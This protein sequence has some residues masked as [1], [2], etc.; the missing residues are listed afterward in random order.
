MNLIAHRGYKTNNVKENTIE[1][2]D[3]AYKLGYKGLE[4]DVRVTKDKKL[5]ICHDAFINRVSNGSGLIKNK[6][7]KE[8]LKYNFG[9]KEKPSKIPL[10]K[11]ILKRYDFIKI[12]ELKEDIDIKQI[13]KYI[14]DNTIFISFNNTRIEK[15]KKEYPKYKYGVLNYVF[16]SDSIYN[17]DIICV[18][19]DVMTK[20]IENYFINKGIIVFIYGINKNIKYVSK[21]KDIYYI[22]DNM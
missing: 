15:L 12:I 10:L 21:N 6:T 5:V 19:E 8:L 22:V 11:T 14:D 4:C 18:L 13:E 20:N 16:N 2:F 3:M 17:L 7:Y 9:T 1:A